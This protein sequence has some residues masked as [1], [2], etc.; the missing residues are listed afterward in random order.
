MVSLVLIAHTLENLHGELLGR[1]VHLNWLEA[2]FQCGVLL[3][4][5]AVL[6]QGGGANGLQLTASQ[7]RL[8]DGGSVDSALCGTGTDESVNLVNE[9]DN[10]TAGANLL[11]HLLEAFLKVT[12]VPGARN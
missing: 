10:V 7:H 5:L 4:V 12:A 11:E 1:L 3:N 6:V 8:Q 9:Q 2:A